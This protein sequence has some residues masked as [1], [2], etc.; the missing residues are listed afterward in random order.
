[1]GRQ[2]G[3]SAYRTGRYA[4]ALVHFAG[5]FRYEPGVRTLYHML[6]TALRGLLAGNAGGTVY[7]SQEARPAV[8]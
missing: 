5:S 8:R 3:C 6:E 7:E 1:L 2:L 4:D